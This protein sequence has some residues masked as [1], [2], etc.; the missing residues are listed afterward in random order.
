[1]CICAYVYMCIC[2]VVCVC[3]HLCIYVHVYMFICV[4]VCSH[5]HIY[6]WLFSSIHTCIHAYICIHI[7]IY[8]FLSCATENSYTIN[9]SVSWKYN[10][11][12]NLHIDNITH[13]KYHIL[14]RK[15]IETNTHKHVGDSSSCTRFS[16]QCDK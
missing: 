9:M 6:R 11:F 1:M 14:I 7:L 4:Y 5:T 8:I 10:E 13:S 15:L 16:Q 2:V 12:K 3:I